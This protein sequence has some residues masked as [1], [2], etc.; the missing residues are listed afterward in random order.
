[1][2][3]SEAGSLGGKLGGLNSKMLGEK[4]RLEYSKNPKTCLFCSEQ[5][6]F[7][8]KRSKFCNHSCAAKFSNNRKG[9]GR[10]PNKCLT[11]GVVI[12]FGVANCEQHR[13]HGKWTPFELLKGDG[14]RKVRLISERGHS[15]ESCKLSTWLNQKIVLTLEHVDGNP[16]NNKKE[17]LKL[18][19]WNCHSLTPFFGAKNKGRFSNS[20]RSIKRKERRAYI[21]GE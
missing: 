17:N 8:K 13:T 18:L 14:T 15:C 21:A 5:I 7:D 2:T 16:D 10:E 9:T 12:S 20:S 1:M 6:P 3:R 11:C 4:L 19:C